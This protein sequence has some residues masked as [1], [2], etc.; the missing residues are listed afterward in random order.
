MM[1]FFSS[2][3]QVCERHTCDTSRP[4]SHS[5]SPARSSLRLTKVF[6]EA[7]NEIIF[8]PAVVQYI[9]T[10]QYTPLLGSRNDGVDKNPFV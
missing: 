9:I 6:K 8:N 5:L 10:T 1:I 4:L 7:I 3:Y 2:M